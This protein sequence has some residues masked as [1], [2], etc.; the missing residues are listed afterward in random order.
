MKNTLI[1]ISIISL[2]FIFWCN[3]NP[4]ITDIINTWE[5]VEQNPV[6]ATWNIIDLTWKDE[7]NLKWASTWEIKNI[8][9][10]YK[11]NNT[12]YWDKIDWNTIDLMEK[13]IEKIEKK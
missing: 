3:K 2:I 4:Q 12:W 9:D 10:E 13:V 8:I 1:I 5:M 11:A 7:N 6:T